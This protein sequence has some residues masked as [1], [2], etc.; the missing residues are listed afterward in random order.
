MPFAHSVNVATVKLLDKVG[1][2]NVII[3]AQK[4]GITEPIP[5]N[6]TTALGLS[7]VTLE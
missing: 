3:N 7:S 2:G 6:L 5:H 1:I 4:L